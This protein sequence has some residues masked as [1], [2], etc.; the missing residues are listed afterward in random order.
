MSRI[1]KPTQRYIEAMETLKPQAKKAIKKQKQ[2]Q[3]LQKKI[4]KAQDNLIK[5]V[6]KPYDNTKELEVIRDTNNTKLYDG[7]YV[8]NKEILTKQIRQVISEF[9]NGFLPPVFKGIVPLYI[10]KAPPVIKE[11]VL[12][13]KLANG[14]YQTKTSKSDKNI[15]DGIKTL[16]KL[17][18]L[19]KYKQDDL[20]DFIKNHR[21]VFYEILRKC[22]ENNLSLPTFKGY[23]VKLMRVLVIAFKGKTQPVY[24]KYASIL[25]DLMNSVEKLDDKNTL[26]ENEQGRYVDWLIIL[27]KQKNL[28]DTF[29]NIPDKKSKKAYDANLDLVLLSLYTL[30]PP[31]RREVLNLY[32]K[33]EGDNLE[34]D[35]INIRRNEVVLNLNLDKKRHDKLDIEC[36]KE[37][38]DILR[39]SYE[40]YPRRYVFTQA[41]LYPKMD[42]KL[43][44]DA[45]AERL[46]KLFIKT[47][48]KSVG[49]SILRSSY[50]TYRYDSAN[51]RLVFEEV[52]EMARL[53][54]TSPQY[55][56]T[57]YRKIIN[58]PVIA[59]SV[60]DN[61]NL[62]YTS[63]NLEVNPNNA[64]K[65][66]WSSGRF[67]APIKRIPPKKQDPYVKH[68][69]AIK[70]KYK[71]NEVYR[72]KTLTQQ[73]EYRAKIGA[74]ELQKRKIVSMLKNS[75]AYR[76]KV[77]SSTLAKYGIDINQFK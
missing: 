15:A 9:P 25:K 37:L 39:Q 66:V 11:T 58:Q 62:Q 55:L 51:G 8:D 59:Y 45:V 49:P 64:D 67:I 3:V 54:R 61:N 76:D 53:M 22:Q 31:L 34:H 42:K 24:V 46:R 20:T 52:K 17:P 57:S 12:L 14:D 71:E 1:R 38:A 47:E 68:N 44:E 23:I 75:P 10:E 69:E 19:E 16:L 77:K 6:S 73:A 74:T 27:Q 65:G 36:S 40:L 56:Q 60:D 5:E 26:N 7:L 2:Q 48:K 50:T 72:N 4:I 29:N 41:N 32:F 13:S 28:L 70:T 21:E 18:N 63:T 35:F 33:Q 30:T 43:G